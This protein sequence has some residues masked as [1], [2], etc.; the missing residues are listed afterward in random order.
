M[1]LAFVAASGFID[2]LF[3]YWDSLGSKGVYSLYN[4]FLCSLLTPSKLYSQQCNRTAYGFGVIG[5]GC[6]KRTA[7]GFTHPKYGLTRL[8]QVRMSSSSLP[9]SWAS[10]AERWMLGGRRL[11]L[12]K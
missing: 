9:A 12:E 11:L 4:A 5:P 10:W 3:T 2:V 6:E 8:W 1:A 7:E